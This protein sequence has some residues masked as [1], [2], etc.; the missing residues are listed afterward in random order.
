MV[1]PGWY[2]LVACF[3]SYPALFGK[4]KVFINMRLYSLNYS[5]TQYIVACGTNY[6]K[7]I[8]G[9]FFHCVAWLSIIIPMVEFLL[10]S[11]SGL[12]QG[13]F[14]LRFYS[15]VTRDLIR[16][17]VHNV[18]TSLEP[19]HRWTDLE[20]S[21]CMQFNIL[22]IKRSCQNNSL[23]NDYEISVKKSQRNGFVY[24]N[25]ASMSSEYM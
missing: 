22:I 15:A 2:G 7:C 16:L 10:V 9:V 3:L 20:V 6:Q 25:K 13:N 11:T 21:F 23:L 24:W 17:Q 19:H 1:C 12:W 5:L 8:H 14:P 18:C 4:R